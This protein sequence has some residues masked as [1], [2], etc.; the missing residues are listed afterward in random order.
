MAKKAYFF[1]QDK[2]RDSLYSLAYLLR[3]GGIP[4]SVFSGIKFIA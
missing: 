1:E 2:K 4:A 3:E